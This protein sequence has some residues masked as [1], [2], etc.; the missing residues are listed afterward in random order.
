M[1][2]QVNFLIK[3]SSSINPE[4]FVSIRLD[5]MLHSL[6]FCRLTWYV[7]FE[8]RWPVEPSPAAPSAHHAVGSLQLFCWWAAKRA[9]HTNI[10]NNE[11]CHQRRAYHHGDDQKKVDSTLHFLFLFHDGRWRVWRKGSGHLSTISSCLIKPHNSAPT[12]SK[13]NENRRECFSIFSAP[14]KLSFQ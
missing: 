2:F 6:D 4:R 9:E 10:A 13:Q 7:G 12:T 8:R 14:H 1:Q 11:G 3:F 5:F